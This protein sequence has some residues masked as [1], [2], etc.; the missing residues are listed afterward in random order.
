MMKVSCTDT[1]DSA[2]YI[3]NLS[4]KF[5]YTAYTCMRQAFLDL[6]E[7][8][9]APLSQEQRFHVSLKLHSK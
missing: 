3:Y 7:G 4:I 2:L 9:K 5:L 8:R 1:E 6:L